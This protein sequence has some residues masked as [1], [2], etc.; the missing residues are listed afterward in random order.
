MRNIL[1]VI[2]V[3]FAATPLL[4]AQESKY[5]YLPIRIVDGDT[6]PYIN[7]APVEVF[8]FRIL[9]S[10]Q[11]IRRNNKLIYNVKKVYPWAKLAGQKLVEYETVLSNVKSDREK[12]RIMKEIEQEIQ[13]QYGGEL[14]KLT[15]SQGKIL[16]KLI[17]RETGN[18]SYD[19][20]EDFR[21]IFVAFF[22]QSFARVFGY[23]LKVTYD[24]EGEDRNIE[25]IVRMIE[26]GMI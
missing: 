3:V 7:L 5:H 14:R 17:D 21:G 9:K 13:D 18:S 24:P 10:K 25:V 2:F 22:Y 19:L 1:L 4:H 8:D 15:F 16:I 20:V 12:R 11:E 23:N 6:L 26:S